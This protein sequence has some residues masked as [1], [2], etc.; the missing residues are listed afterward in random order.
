MED[1]ESTN[2]DVDLELTA[3]KITILRDDFI[4]PMEDSII[5]F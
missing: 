2:V 1:L 4:S 5:S 3:L